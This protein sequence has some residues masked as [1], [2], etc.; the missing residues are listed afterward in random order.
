MSR[1]LPSSVSQTPWSDTGNASLWYEKLAAFWYP[2]WTLKARGKDPSPKLSWI[3]SVTPSKIGS[4]DLLA[5]VAE[6]QRRLAA[7]SGGFVLTLKNRSTF[8][9]GL[10]ESHPVESGF[11]WHSPLGVPY[12]PGSGIKGALKTWLKEELP[13]P[14]PGDKP[15]LPR[16]TDEEIQEILGSAEDGAGAID[17][18]PM[19]PTAPVRLRAD[20]VNPHHVPYQRG[21]EW[22]ADWQSPVPS[23]F[24]AVAPSNLWQLAVVPRPGLGSTDLA[25][26]LIGYLSEAADQIGFGAKTAVG[27]GR[28]EIASLTGSKP[29]KNTGRP[30]RG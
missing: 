24:L 23:F 4:E 29:A 12:L 28:F 27:Y 19:L 11:A 2:D 14:L 5:E 9:T 25:Q 8:V 26:S 21:N 6:R 18:L 16:P 13:Q 30:A 7:A 15:F 17:F 22:P 20:L 10:G 3:Q 1:P